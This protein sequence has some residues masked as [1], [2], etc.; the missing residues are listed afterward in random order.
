MSTIKLPGTA[1]GEA[2]TEKTAAIANDCVALVDRAQRNVV[3]MYDAQT[4]SAVGNGKISHVVSRFNM[5]SIRL[6]CGKYWSRFSFP[7]FGVLISSLSSIYAFYKPLKKLSG[8]RRTGNV[9]CRG[10]A[11]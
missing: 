11:G 4:A 5:S 1:A 10:Y 7:M 8:L 2:W 6:F 3:L 9:Q